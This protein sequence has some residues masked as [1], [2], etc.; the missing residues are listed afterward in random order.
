MR[1][2]KES[3]LQLLL[4]SLALLLSA[5]SST[6]LAF[7]FTLP[8]AS[9]SNNKR[10]A[11]DYSTPTTVAPD[12]ASPVGSSNALQFFRLVGK[13]KTTKRTGWVNHQVQ[14]P[15]SIAD[16]MYRMSMLAMLITDPSIDK[17]RLVKICL[18]HD[19]AESIVGDITP[20]DVRYTA[21]EK[22]RLELEAMDKIGSDVGHAG[23]AAELKGLWLEYE[24]GQ[25]A[26]SKV[27]KQLDKYEMIVQADEYERAQ[28]MQLKT[29][30]DSTRHAFTH[31]EVCAWAEEL[32]TQRD[33]RLRG[34]AASEL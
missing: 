28:D 19:L 1:A 24:D 31:P 5:L 30:F 9:T 2:H 23:I 34:E 22:R 8:A 33:R 20:T 15:E 10:M 16:H 32:W 27:A 14:L 25:T 17:D 4:A 12:A 18:V 29:F 3:F 21:E 26:E 13:L 6:H 11:T 7:A